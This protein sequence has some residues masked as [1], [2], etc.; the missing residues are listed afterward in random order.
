ML[1][2]P[3]A[4]FFSLAPHLSPQVSIAHLQ[5]VCQ[6]RAC[7]AAAFTSLFVCGV[8]GWGAGTWVREISTSQIRLINPRLKL[9]AE[10]SR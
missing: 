8:D 2:L 4:F 7:E 10:E 9:L 1:C 3:W 5:H 6:D